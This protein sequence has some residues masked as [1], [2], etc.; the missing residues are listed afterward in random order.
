VATPMARLV[1]ITA[2]LTGWKVLFLFPSTLASLVARSREVSLSSKAAHYDVKI[3][4]RGYQ[5][6]LDNLRCTDAS[7]I[8]LKLRGSDYL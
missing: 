8:W 2:L 6:S 1:R 3:L 5:D 4:A 7:R